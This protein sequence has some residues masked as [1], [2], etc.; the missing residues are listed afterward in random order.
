MTFLKA[1][2]G[3]FVAVL[4][5]WGVAVPCPRVSEPVR[6]GLVAEGRELVVSP[7]FDKPMAAAKIE[8]I[9]AL[10]AARGRPDLVG[11]M[12]IFKSV[13]VAIFGA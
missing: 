11:T 12:A 4:T 13:G 8:C 9:S 3:G 5:L 6:P 1:S 2:I 10:S 7:R